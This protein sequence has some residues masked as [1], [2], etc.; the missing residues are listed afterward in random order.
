MR[1]WCGNLSQER[2]LKLRA[3]TQL[4]TNLRTNF[5]R[6]TINTYIYLTFH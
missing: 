1:G 5:S 3:Q 2:Q 4:P 6:E